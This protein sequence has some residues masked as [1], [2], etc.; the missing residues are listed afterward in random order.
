MVV[1]DGHSFLPISFLCE[2][3]S[4]KNSTGSQKNLEMSDIDCHHFIDLQIK[5]E[6]CVFS[7]GNLLAVRT[8]DIIS[9]LFASQRNVHLK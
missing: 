7:P 4:Q 8:W 2:I 3:L 6:G 5:M 9:Q 1:V